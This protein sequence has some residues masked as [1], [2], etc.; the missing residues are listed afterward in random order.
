MF[1]PG[2]AFGKLV[3]L[4]LEVNH[5]LL[6]FLFEQVCGLLRFKMD[7][8]QEL[9]E[10]GKFGVAFPVDLE[11]KNVCRHFKIRPQNLNILRWALK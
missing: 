2:F 11:L 3:D 1:L 9:A 10:L 5:D 6:M 8:F 4:V 7:I